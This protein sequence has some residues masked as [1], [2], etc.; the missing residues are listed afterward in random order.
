MKLVYKKVVRLQKHFKYIS[1]GNE[2]DFEF[3]K[4]I[5]TKG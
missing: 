4:F 1:K 2:E 5:L 3:N